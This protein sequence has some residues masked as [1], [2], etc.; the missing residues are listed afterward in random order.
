MY[1]ELDSWLWL[2]TWRIPYVSLLWLQ[3]VSHTS[4][5]FQV[6]QA[7]MPSLVVA[8]GSRWN[9]CESLLTWAWAAAAERRIVFSKVYRGCEISPGQ[10][11]LEA[12]SRH[13]DPN[14]S[15]IGK[16][17]VLLKQKASED[18]K[19]MNFIHYVTS[20]GYLGHS[21]SFLIELLPLLDVWWVRSEPIQKISN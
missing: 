18:R 16:M 5:I 10:T 9:A 7:G 14:Y 4:W 11:V 2:T 17:W 8:L 1:K 19:S 3:E 15:V 20:P 12:R 6:S 21:V 13:S